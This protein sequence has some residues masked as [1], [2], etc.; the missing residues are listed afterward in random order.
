[1]VRTGLIPERLFWAFCRFYILLIQEV[2]VHERKSPCRNRPLPCVLTFRKRTFPYS[3]LASLLFFL[4]KQGDVRA[5][6]TLRV[7][8]E[9]KAEPFPA[10]LGGFVSHFL[11]SLHFNSVDNKESS[12][13]STCQ[14]YATALCLARSPSEDNLHTSASS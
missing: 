1:M 10:A 8:R 12:L 4:E 11:E 2:I 9:E 13:F 6:D 5:V 7:P 14:L 3:P